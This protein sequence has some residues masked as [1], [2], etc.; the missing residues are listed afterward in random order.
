MLNTMK[1]LLISAFMFFIALSFCHTAAAVKI[2]GL[3]QAKLL[4]L[5]QDPKVR[6][7]MAIEGLKRVIVKASGSRASLAN[8]AVQEALAEANRYVQE[9]SYGQ[10]SEAGELP[11]N[12]RFNRAAV[13]K[14]LRNAD[15][16]Y[17]PENRPAILLWLVAEGLVSGD[18]E[19]IA[20]QDNIDI[21]AALAAAVEL[22]GLAIDSPLLDLDDSLGFPANLAWRLDRSGL[23]RASSRYDND[24]VVL[25]RLSQTGTGE[26]RG[27]WL[28]DNKGEYQIFD[29]RADDREAMLVAGF[30]QLADYLGAQFSV[31]SKD[32]DAPPVLMQLDGVASFEAYNHVLKYLNGLAI[33]RHAEPN[34]LSAEVMGLRIYFDGEVQQLKDAIALGAVLQPMLGDIAADNG[35]SYKYQPAEI[36]EFDP[37]GPE[38]E[39]DQAE[40]VLKPGP[41]VLKIEPEES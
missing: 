4:V 28:L 26:W 34:S 25:V 1:T 11:L 13:E 39:L 12:L 37:A 29:A 31:V 32:D 6:R 18:K 20:P 40:T 21:A 7:K 3:Y 16:A 8:P 5:S 15:L 2:E 35:L 27:A 41:L 23:S 38:F 22:R 30:E 9:F 10:I 36:I 33:V 14:L 19:L 24:I 17:W